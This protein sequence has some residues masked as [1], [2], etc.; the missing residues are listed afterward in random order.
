MYDVFLPAQCCEHAERARVNGR[1]IL[2]SSSPSSNQNAVKKNASAGE[3]S[4]PTQGQHTHGSRFEKA[5]HALTN[6]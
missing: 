1:K 2:W 6:D 3:P 5:Q 4:G